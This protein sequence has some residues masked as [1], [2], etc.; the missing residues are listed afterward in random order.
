M[1]P[2][3]ERLSG[4]A[5]AARDSS[6]T[7]TGRRE[8]PADDLFVPAAPSGRALGRAR[9]R[10]ALMLLP[11]LL[12]GLTVVLVIAAAIAPQLM[13]PFAPTDMD[14]AAT[15][16]APGGAHIL[17]TDQFGRDV[18]SLVIYGARQ[19]ALMA[20]CAM[21][22]SCTLG[23][24]IG[25]LAG[26]AG[27]VWDMVL[28]RIVDVWLA[29]PNILLAI[30]ICTALNPSLETTIIAVSIT[31]VPRYARVLRAQALAIRVRPFI[32]AAR[33]S[34][35]SHFAIL[36]RHVL[37]HCLATILV[38]ATLGV[39]TSVLLGSSLSFLGLGINDERPDWGYLLTQGRGYLTVAWW[40]VTYPGLALTLLVVSVNLLGDALRRWLVPNSSPVERGGLP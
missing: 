29:I 30:A 8:R 13:A 1:K 6:V 16:S 10:A 7:I 3:A 33:A 25:L 15:L 39:G 9:A 32:L 26:Y 14:S 31:T 40:S 23:V 18:L 5:P 17:G 19:S 11:T 34:G 35:A 20:I 37:P 2:A 28:M 4:A 12:S 36:R 24:T 38:L 27:G 21:L 22:L